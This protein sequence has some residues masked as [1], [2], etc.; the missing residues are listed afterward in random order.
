[1]EDRKQTLIDAQNL[2][3][4]PE[5]YS[6]KLEMERF[7]EEMESI[8]DLDLSDVSRVTLGEEIAGRVWASKK[9]RDMLSTL[10]LVDKS[11][12]KIIDRT[13]E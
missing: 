5:F 10:G 13:G 1:M 4:Y 9:V 8:A 2:K 11:K 3:K 12:P 6:L 7:C